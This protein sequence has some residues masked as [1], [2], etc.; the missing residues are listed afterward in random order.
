MTQGRSRTGRGSTARFRTLG[1]AL[2]ARLD[3]TYGRPDNLIPPEAD[4]TSSVQEA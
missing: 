3:V 1:Q 4:S 2:S